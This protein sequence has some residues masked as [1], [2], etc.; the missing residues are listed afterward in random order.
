MNLPNF[1]IVGAQKSGTTT[2]YDILNEHPEVN[3]SEVKEINYFTSKEKV[4][5]GLEFYSKYFT[6]NKG[7]EKIRGEASPGYICFPGAAKSIKSMLG[8]VKIVMILRDPIKRAF[9]QYWDNR[10]HLS[11]NLTEDEIIKSFL[12][13]DYDPEKRGYF[14]RGVYIN[15]IEEYLRYF[16]A[17]SIHIIILEELLEKPQIELKKLFE[18]LNIDASEKHLELTKSSNSSMIWQNPIYKYFLNNPGSTK[19]LPR[20]F[21]R[22]LF[23]GERT[24]YKYLLP[25]ES[26][27]KVLQEFYTPWIK[28]LESHLGRDMKHWSLSKGKK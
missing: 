17:S 26:N 4:D 25:N 24:K 27:I 21:R 8:E 28:K 14:S 6:E 13:P 18:F 19:V 16:D 10:R 5:K 11:E 22:L 1:L 2:L 23:F 7:E 20:Q 12:F 3:M 9:S 15:Y